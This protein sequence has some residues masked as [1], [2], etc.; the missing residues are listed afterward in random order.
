MKKLFTLISFCL[1]CLSLSAQNL[2]GQWSGTIKKSFEEKPFLYE[3]SI[4]ENAGGQSAIKYKD[5]EWHCQKAHRGQV[6]N[7]KYI[8]ADS[9]FI[10]HH[11]DRGAYWLMVRGT[12]QYDAEK[13]MLYGWVDA[14][15]F[16]TKSLYKEHDY[17]ELY[18]KKDRVAVA[19]SLPVICK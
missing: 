13:D 16:Y 18:R 5:E 8:Y 11:H 17:V 2:S 12:L 7:N 9:R 3:L 10:I 19:A 15:D 1:C 14:Y 4:V 6:A